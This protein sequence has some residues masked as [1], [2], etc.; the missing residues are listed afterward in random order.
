[1]SEEAEV[2]EDVQLVPISTY[3]KTKMVA[4]KVFLSYADHIAVHCVRPG[5]VCGWSPRMRLD[6]TVNILTWH[7]LTKGVV[8]VL[9]GQQTRPNI[10]IDD[11]V[12]S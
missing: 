5:T 11:M 6:L 3:N 7:A 4:E 1:M 12:S 2:T 8:T 10:H 9:G